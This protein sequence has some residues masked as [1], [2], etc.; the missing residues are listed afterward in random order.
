MGSTA[1]ELLPASGDAQTWTPS[2]L[3]L[4]ESIGLRGWK[5]VQKNGRWEKERFE[6]PRATV[7]AFLFQCRRTQL[8]PVARQ[9][10]CIERGGKWG[11]QASIDGFRLIA[12]R[13]NQYRGQTPVQWTADG[14]V[15]VDVWLDESTPP[16]AA[17]VGVRR[18]GFDEPLYAVAT[19][20]GYVPRDRSGQAKP[21]GQWLTNP[22][23]QLA[24]CTEMLALRKAFPQD[25]SGIY[26]TEEMQQ[27]S[28]VKSA[29]PHVPP[30]AVEAAP[31]TFSE[32]WVGQ[33]TACTTVDELR[34]IFERA[35]MAGELDYPV[36]ET[37]KTLNVFLR[38]LKQKL[39]E[40]AAPEVTQEPETVVEPVTE[41]PVR[42][43]GTGVVDEATGEVLY[44]GEEII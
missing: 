14:V 4:M 15:W 43:P 7:E 1:I 22:S 44:E 31:K 41:W 23:N 10:Y 25:L 6:A 12:E 24:K 20:A 16:A 32:D 38:E 29:Q 21:T 13:S 33:G 27:V 17:R 19:Y 42:E 30:A 8:D 34:P 3:A 18:D 36:D 26:G 39:V 37:G 9:I 35:Q 40:T 28:K 11:I 2:E 5:N